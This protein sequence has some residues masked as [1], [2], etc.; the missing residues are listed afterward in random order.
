MFDKTV[1][2]GSFKD[3]KA[4]GKGKYYTDE[5]NLTFEGSWEEG[6]MIEGKFVEQN[7]RIKKN[8]EV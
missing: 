7:I 4:H 2:N 5:A 3:G 1:Y 8:D 6:E